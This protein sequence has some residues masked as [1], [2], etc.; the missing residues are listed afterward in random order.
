MTRKSFASIELKTHP[1]V[2]NEKFDLSNSYDES[3]N[4]KEI[5]LDI[6][7]SFKELN[8]YSD[9][10][11]GEWNWLQKNKQNNFIKSLSDFNIEKL[12]YF[13]TNMFKTEATYGLLSPS[14]SDCIKDPE[15]FKSNI[16]CNIDVCFEFTDIQNLEQLKTQHGNPYGLRIKSGIVLPDS[17]RHY[18]FGYNISRLL[19]EKIS[20]PIILKLV[21]VMEGYVFKIGSNSM[22]I[23]L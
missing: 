19:R 10:G 8:E 21:G 18:Y 2:N 23:V 22:V 15:L 13:L 4:D 20:N 7:T 1:N 17:P 11:T 16:L 3:T 6:F 14:Y 12:T 5:I 9:G